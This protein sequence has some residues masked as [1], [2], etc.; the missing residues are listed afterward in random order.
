MEAAGFDHGAEVVIGCLLAISIVIG[1]VLARCLLNRNGDSE[2]KQARKALANVL[3]DGARS[4][5]KKQGHTDDD[6]FDVP[7]NDERSYQGIDLNADDALTSQ[8]SYTKAP[9][10]P[11]RKTGRATASKKQ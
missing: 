8:T 1:A 3:N 10:K 9:S 6:M 7:L 4:S 2:T 11:Q 5:E